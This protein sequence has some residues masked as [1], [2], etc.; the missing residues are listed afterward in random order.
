VGR[1]AYV[2][3]PDARSTESSVFWVIVILQIGSGNT[4]NNVAAQTGLKECKKEDERVSMQHNTL[5]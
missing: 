5:K 4:Q 3:F 2:N 1:I